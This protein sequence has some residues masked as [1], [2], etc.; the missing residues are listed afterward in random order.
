M[1]LV[2]KKRRNSTW[3]FSLWNREPQLLMR[4]MRWLSYKPHCNKAPHNHWW[5][6]S[7]LYIRQCLFILTTPRGNS[8]NNEVTPQGFPSGAGNLPTSHSSQS[9]LLLKHHGVLGSDAESQHWAVWTL[10]KEKRSQNVQ[11]SLRSEF[12]GRVRELFYFLPLWTPGMESIS[13]SLKHH[14][15]QFN[16]KLLF[17]EIQGW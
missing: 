3:F 13:I 15:F 14:L 9:N 2:A 11:H 5:I 8:S 16:R 17:N 12:T 6:S 10:Q 1:L 4:Y 7:Y